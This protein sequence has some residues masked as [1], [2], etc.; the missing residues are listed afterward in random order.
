MSTIDGLTQELLGGL[1]RAGLG[2]ATVLLH[3]S[4]GRDERVPGRSDVN[5]VCIVDQLSP[6]VLDSLG[7]VLRR[8]Q[9]GAG[10]LPL[11]FTRTEWQR[12]ADAYPLEIAEMQSG[13]RVLQGPDLLAPLRVD[14]ADLRLALER[15]LRGKLLRL[16][17]GAAVIMDDSGRAGLVRASLPAVLFL[18][19]ALLI[20]GE[21][22]VP[23]STAEVARAMA[24]TI[25]AEA[26]EFVAIAGRRHD[27]SWTCGP[28]PLAGYLAVVERAVLFVD[29]FQTGGQT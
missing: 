14:R 19:R 7:P 28:G 21:Q 10:S 24:R 26:E 1:G 13:Y 15:E 16:R 22:R 20:L 29:H 3:G 2:G 5:A 25:G 12:S 4:A 18:A 9:A 11:L 6:G 23:A 17:Q 8:W 27:E